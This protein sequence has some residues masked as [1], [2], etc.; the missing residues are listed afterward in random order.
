MSVARK[1][2]VQGQVSVGRHTRVIL[3]VFTILTALVA[4]RVGTSAAQSWQEPLQ[5][6]IRLTPDVLL[7]PTPANNTIVGEC[8]FASSTTG[9]V[10]SAAGVDRLTAMFPEFD[11]EDIA[12]TNTAGEP[13]TLLDLSTFYIASLIA[14]TDPNDLWFGCA[15]AEH[16]QSV[17]VAQSRRIR[18]RVCYS[19]R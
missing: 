15:N 6:V 10:L 2:L 11:A 4:C 14:G 9:P 3:R 7:S 18:V 5:L 8:T 17:V 19:N 16:F 13:V 12:T 1:G